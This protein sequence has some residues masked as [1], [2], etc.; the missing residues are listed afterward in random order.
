M[1][2]I[3]F[4]ALTEKTRFPD[5]KQTIVYGTGIFEDGINTWLLSHDKTKCLADGFTHSIIDKNTIGQFTELHDKNGKE[6]YEG[7]ILEY[8]DDHHVGQKQTQVIWIECTARFALQNL[9]MEKYG[10]AEF[11]MEGKHHII[12]GNI[13]ENPELLKEKP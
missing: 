13:Y 8:E 6:I 10:A 2:E 4:R 11:G 12:I 1:R 3:K 7:D 9:D 5:L